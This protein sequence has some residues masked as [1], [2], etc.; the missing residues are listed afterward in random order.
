M[1]QIQNSPDTVSILSTLAGIIREFNVPVDQY[2]RHMGEPV[3]YDPFKSDASTG[4]IRISGPIPENKGLFG[5]SRIIE[6]WDWA[7]V[8]DGSGLWERLYAN[9]IKPLKKQDFQFIFHLGDIAKKRVFEID[10]VLDIIGDYSYYGK[11]TLMLG[12]DEAVNL[13]N[14]LNGRSPDDGIDRSGSLM[15]KEKYRFIFNTMNIGFLVVLHGYCAVLLFRH[16]QVILPCLPP[17]RNRTEVNA[18]ARFSTGY[19]IGLLLQ[20]ETRYCMAIGLAVLGVEPG[21]LLGLN[22]LQLLAYIRD[23]INIL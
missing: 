19:Q 8:Q 11:V 14:R 23:W 15:A 4:Y 5:S 13:W 10:E 9:V 18:R 20:M 1:Y 7:A 22:S 2:L 16:G 3:I 21:P 12:N 17:T 6:F